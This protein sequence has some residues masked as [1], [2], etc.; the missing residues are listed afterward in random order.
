MSKLQSE[1]DFRLTELDTSTLNGQ[2]ACLR[3]NPNMT[4][5]GFVNWSCMMHEF[6]EIEGMF[7]H[8]CYKY[9]IDN[10]E[11]I[12]KCALEFNQYHQTCEHVE[13]KERYKGYRTKKCSINGCRCSMFVCPLFKQHHYKEGEKNDRINY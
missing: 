13:F 11:D 12:I 3:C 4:Y 5:A 1:G 7:C 10:Q 2:S 6:K 8:H 9:I